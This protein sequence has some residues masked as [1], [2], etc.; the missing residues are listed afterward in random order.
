[1]FPPYPAPFSLIAYIKARGY[2]NAVREYEL[3]KKALD[4][5][6]PLLIAFTVLSVIH[7]NDYSN[8][9]DTRGAVFAF[10]QPFHQ[11]STILHPHIG[12][13]KYVN[14]LLVLIVTAAILKVIFAV[15]RKDFRLYFARGCFMIIQ[16]K[17]DEVEKMGYFV[18]GLNSYNL[19]LRR[20]IKL[21]IDDLKPIYSKIASS[22]SQLKNEVISKVSN[23]FIDPSM[24]AA[25]LEPVR[26]LYQLMDMHSE[27]PMLTAQPLTNKLKDY[28]AAAVVVIPLMIQLFTTFAL[29]HV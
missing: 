1:M 28:T 25:T 24:E 13:F 6:V 27:T 12:T 19:Y 7:D 16:G 14:T 8:T 29:H 18:R 23:D 26:Y 2:K 22:S 21:Q 9:K 17:N 4:I 20:H 15:A 3:V 10:A 5:S 11:L